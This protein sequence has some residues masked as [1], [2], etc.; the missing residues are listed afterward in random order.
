M[1]TNSL[2]LVMAIVMWAG[3][4][5]NFVPQSHR[6]NLSLVTHIHYCEVLQENMEDKSGKRAFYHIQ[7]VALTFKGQR[8]TC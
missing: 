6:S 1:L 5:G 2:E 8:G 3:D 7:A 4:G